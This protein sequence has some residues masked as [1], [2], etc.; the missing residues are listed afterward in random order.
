MR[1]PRR[2]RNSIL[3]LGVIAIMGAGLVW[4][5]PGHFGGFLSD[6]PGGSA[7]QEADQAPSDADDE[8]R[9]T[10]TIRSGVTLWHYDVGGRTRAEL[11]AWLQELGAAAAREPVDAA[12]DPVTAGVVPGLDGAVVNMDATVKE[13]LA[14]STGED[15]EPVYRFIRPARRLADLAPAPLWQ[16]NPARRQVTFLINVAWGDEFVPRLLDILSDY[17]VRASFFLVGA[18][19]SRS[20]E[21]AR[22]IAGAGHEIANH[23]SEA[24]RH[25]PGSLGRESLARHIREAAAA[26]FET[27]GVRP[28]FFSPHKG[29]I[30][31]FMAAVA[32]AERHQLVLWSIDTVDWRDPPP[33]AIVSRV[34][35]RLHGGGLILMHPRA[36][37]VAALPDLLEALRE[38]DYELI[39]LAE[40]TASSLPAHLLPQPPREFPGP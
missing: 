15:V 35:E 2:R 34:L 29:E 40:M 23:G 21:L 17:D 22:A 5:W 24:G 14:A 8:G 28:R 10:A 27:T 11:R 37:T 19:A 16:G 6:R 7:G 38:N 4:V 18:W 32:A 26:I 31:S 12:V 30:N 9:A 25:G 13:L 39:T 1:S 33:G 20:P 3:I 36:V